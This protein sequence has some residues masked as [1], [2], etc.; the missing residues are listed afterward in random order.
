M[1]HRLSATREWPY[2][3]GLDQNDV[4][5]CIANI[6]DGMR[7]MSIVLRQLSRQMKSTQAEPNS[8]VALSTVMTLANLLE[9]S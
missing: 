2:I 9:N 4:Q 1:N 8:V 7:Q 6:E 5:N 3:I